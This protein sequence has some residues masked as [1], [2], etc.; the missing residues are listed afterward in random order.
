MTDYELVIF[1]CDGVLIDSEL[2][3]ARM[4]VAELAN[5]QVDV[6]LAY[7]VHHFLGRSY[8]VVISQIRKE[9]GLELPPEFE[10]DYRARL[11]AAF[12]EELEEMPGVRE[13][14]AA[15]AVPC[16]V[17]TSSSPPR[18]ERALE[19]VGMSG[20]F[21]DRVYTA[22]EVS[23]GK[24]A[25]DLFLHAA[26]KMGAAP[27]RC[28]VIEDSLNGVRAGLSAGMTVWQFT[29]GSHMS[30]V[31]LD[32]PDLPQA[33][34]RFASFGDFFHPAPSLERTRPIP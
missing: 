15:L 32:A 5:W 1:D 21:G 4:L 31:A 30:G 18:V 2:I 34:R 25:P 17:A 24:P 11:L 20:L 23:R 9:F 13:V 12:D 33:H 8:P 22:S 6:D 28:L 16:C 19:I 29:G 3:S 26:A 14:I 10:A 27:K 7:V